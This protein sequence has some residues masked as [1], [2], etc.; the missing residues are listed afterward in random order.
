MLKFV[1]Q[2]L[3]GPL[4]VAKQFVFIYLFIYFA[5][6]LFFIIIHIQNTMVTAGKAWTSNGWSILYYLIA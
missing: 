1:I 6:N 5:Y 2:R 4:H 3:T